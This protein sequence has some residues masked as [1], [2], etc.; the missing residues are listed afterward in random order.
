MKKITPKQIRRFNDAI[1]NWFCPDSEDS[2]LVRA[3]IKDRLDLLGVLDL[4]KMGNF[5]QAGESARDLDTI[6][7]D[8]IPRDIY[9]IIT[10]EDAYDA[11]AAE[12]AEAEDTPTVS[13]DPNVNWANDENQFARFIAEA[14][15]NGAFEDNEIFHRM[16]DSMDLEISQIHE[17][18]ER[19]QKKWDKIKS[20]T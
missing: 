20:Q 3:Y 17:I 19:A 2:S 9:D 16:A 5:R 7:R 4:I 11:D 18:I 12:A 10:A 13:K 15:A 14:E 8:Q 1:R 6:V